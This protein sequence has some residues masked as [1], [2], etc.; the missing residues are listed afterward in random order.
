MDVLIVSIR[1]SVEPIQP[2]V[3]LRHALIS[4]PRILL[5]FAPVAPQPVAPQPLLELPQLATVPLRLPTGLAIRHATRAL[6]REGDVVFAYVP[7]VMFHRLG[8]VFLTTEAFALPCLREQIHVGCI[9]STALVILHPALVH[10]QEVVNGSL[11]VE[12][13]VGFLL[14][15][16]DALVAVVIVPLLQCLEL[17]ILPTRFSRFAW[18]LLQ[19][20]VLEQLRQ[21]HALKVVTPQPLIQPHQL[22]LPLQPHLA[23]LVY[24]LVMVVVVGQFFQTLVDQLVFA[25]TRR[26]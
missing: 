26:Q 11:V 10:A 13:I 24:G 21:F 3:R 4:N 22:Q 5:F 17:A 15:A 23:E 19:L 7:I 18:G 1:I 14:V 2:N 25:P 20:Q 12:Q 8:F 16:V 6:R 9:F